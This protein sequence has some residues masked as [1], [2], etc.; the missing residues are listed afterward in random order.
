MC[1]SSKCCGKKTWSKYRTGVRKKF[2]D[3]RKENWEN[4][5]SEELR[6]LEGSM[7]RD[8]EMMFDDVEAGS[9]FGSDDY[10]NDPENSESPVIYSIDSLSLYNDF[11]TGA[12]QA[13][14]QDLN[15]NVEFNQN[16]R[17][18]DNIDGAMKPGDYYRVVL[19]K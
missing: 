18:F 10:E 16:S 13:N 6:V 5:V 1:G 9:D 4:R 15:T 8:I 11:G 3:F 14:T 12:E 7:R 17:N 2:E 19:Q